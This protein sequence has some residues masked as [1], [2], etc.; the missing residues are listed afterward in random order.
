[1]MFL[2]CEE[3]VSFF[4][5]EEGDNW[6]LLICSLFSKDFIPVHPAANA[7]GRLLWTK[8]Y[9][10]G[11]AGASIPASQAHHGAEFSAQV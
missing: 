2:D 3:S 4:S 1:M 11:F 9:Q 6:G 7:A 8:V 10:A 5:Y